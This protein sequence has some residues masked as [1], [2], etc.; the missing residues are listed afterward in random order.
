MILMEHVFDA[1]CASSEYLCLPFIEGKI[2][3]VRVG[4]QQHYQN[5]MSPNRREVFFARRISPR[6]KMV[7]NYFGKRNFM[8]P[9]GRLSYVGQR[10]GPLYSK[11]EL[12]FGEFHNFIFVEWWANQIGSLQ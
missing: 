3:F 10:E 1:K 12:Y 7:T 2:C 11:I 4:F 5:L 9:M 8:Q 6:P